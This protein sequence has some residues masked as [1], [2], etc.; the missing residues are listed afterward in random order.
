ME[1][2]NKTKKK[3]FKLFDAVLATVCITLVADS[4]APT[5]SIGNSQFFWWILLLVAFCLPYGLISAE[6][7][8]TYPS[9]G[10]MYDWV[11][12]AFG[13]KWAGRV[14][15]N[16]WINFPLW[17]A[18]LATAITDVVMG[19]FSI[20]LSLW[21][22]LVIQLGYTFLVSFLGIFRI[23]D[24]KYI[25]NLGTFFKIL[26]MCGLGFLGIFV[27]VKYGTANEYTFASLFPT[28][29]LAGIGFVSVIIFNFLGFEVVSTFANDLQNPKKEIPKAIIIGG[30]LMAIFYLLPSF[31]INVAI[32]VE[33]IP[34]STGITES[35][36]ILLASIGVPA[37]VTKGIIIA[38]GLMFIYTMVAN[39][40]SWSFGVNSVAKYSADD[41]GLPKVFAK[42]NKA[43]VPYMSSI[44]N[45]VVAAVIIIIGLLIPES[46]ADLF[47]TFFSFSL[48]TLL[49]SYLPLFPAF[50]KLRKKD[51]NVER[52]YKIEGG[53]FKLRLMTIVPLI[54]L[55]LGIF[56]TLF[57]EF[58]VEMFSY[59]WPLISGVCLSVLIQEILVSRIKE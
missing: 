19:I 27:A 41:G 4:V 11:K 59:Q 30:I 3:K 28:L 20:E 22:L 53:K 56:F 54:L 24:S 9:E 58:N 32:P 25:V 49:I 6:L 16:Y 23:G 39:I 55:I 57:P 2:E 40:V 48:V 5:A 35:F 52:P 12:R 18:S 7:G 10:G 34:T 50:L 21:W 42:T 33:E 38:V 8:S 26:F 51:P 31:G 15:W 29:D 14:A 1:K 43:G 45:G 46:G 36:A 47:W 13:K 17:I 44:L 37:G